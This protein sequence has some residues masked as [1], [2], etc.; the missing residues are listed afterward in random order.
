MRLSSQ[1]SS[2]PLRASYTFA[3]TCMYTDVEYARRHI[4]TARRLTVL[5]ALWSDRSLHREEGS[6]SRR[7]SPLSSV[8]ASH[9][10][11]ACVAC[12]RSVVHAVHEACPHYVK[13]NTP[14]RCLHFPCARVLAFFS[15][16]VCLLLFL[17]FR[18]LPRRD[19]FRWS[20]SPL[21]SKRGA[22]C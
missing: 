1:P 16:S 10:L 2:Q 21:V 19:T 8:I 11:S 22:E 4:Q 9:V 12:E 20:W 13:E 14:E 6:W 15:R 3:Y 17:S 18:V 5:V 7:S